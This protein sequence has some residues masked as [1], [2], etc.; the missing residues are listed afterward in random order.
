MKRTVLFIA[1]SGIAALVIVSCK[2]SDSP[3]SKPSQ[4]SLIGTYKLASYTASGGGQT[5]DMMKYMDAC[6]KDD[7]ILLKADSVYQYVDAGTTC[8][9]NG[10]WSGQWYVSNS[11]FIIDQDTSN[12]K[13]FNGSSLVLTDSY[14]DQGMTVTETRTFTKQ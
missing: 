10:N 6:L 4:Q 7:Q 11:Y 9:S 12:I 8:N 3:N 14:T 2:K 1:I 5:E 13:S